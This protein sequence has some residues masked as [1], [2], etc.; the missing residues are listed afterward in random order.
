MFFHNY[1]KCF[2]YEQVGIQFECNINTNV[3]SQ[4][5]LYIKN[6]LFVGG[7]KPSQTMLVYS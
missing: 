7:K 2:I 5:F 1:I 3:S 6:Y 4:I